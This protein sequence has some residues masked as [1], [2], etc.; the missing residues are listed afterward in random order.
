MDSLINLQK[1]IAYSLID[2]IQN[3][4]VTTDRATQIAHN[5]EVLLP[6]FLTKE[7]L[8]EAFTYIVKIPELSSI[9]LDLNT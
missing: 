6:D 1:Q 5:I 8:R 3:N 4:E 7:Q 9:K 2:K